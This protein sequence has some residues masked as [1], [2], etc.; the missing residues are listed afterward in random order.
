MV[1]SSKSVAAERVGDG[2]SEKA[3]CYGDEK[4]VEHIDVSWCA[5]VAMVM[6][7]HKGLVQHSAHPA[8]YFV[9][10][11]ASLRQIS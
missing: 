6:R 11:G 4:Q 5:L 10:F 8:R 1:T 9:G 7:L 3:D 2:K